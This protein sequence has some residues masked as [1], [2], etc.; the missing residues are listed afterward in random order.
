[1]TRKSATAGRP[2]KCDSPLSRWLDNSGLSRDEAATELEISRPHL[3]RLCRQERRPSLDLAVRIET[4][5]GGAVTT[6]SWRAV[7]THS[8]D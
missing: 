4:L 6:A 5:T 3:D 8:R 7:P 1:M 2:R